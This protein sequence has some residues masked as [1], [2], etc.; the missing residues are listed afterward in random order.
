MVAQLQGVVAS[1]DDANEEMKAEMR[2]Q[3]TPGKDALASLAA[4]V[5]GKKAMVQEVAGE[6]NEQKKRVTEQVRAEREPLSNPV[7]FPARL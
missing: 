1:I 3:M 4:A 5:E 2:E 7:V 6:I